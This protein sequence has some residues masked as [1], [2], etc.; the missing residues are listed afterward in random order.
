VTE[1]HAKILKFH[2]IYQQDDRDIRA[3]R[4]R[5][6]LEPAYQFM[7]RIRL[8]GGVLSSE[9]LRQIIA[10]SDR[11]ADGT[12]RLTTRQ[13]FQLHGVRKNSL[14][15]V[16]QALSL[17]GLDTIAACGDDNRGVMCAVDPGRSELH[18]DVVELARQISD[19]FI[20]QSGLT[21]KFG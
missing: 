10:I 16:V 19:R 21:G 7:M 15:P 18:S 8:P 11:Y 20:P 5:R 13:T 4:R 17:A 2:G 9:Q 6:K 12:L 1:S 3:E 14:Q